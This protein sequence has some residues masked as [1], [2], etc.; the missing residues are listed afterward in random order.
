MRAIVVRPNTV[1]ARVPVAVISA[2]EE[3]LAGLAGSSG[4]ACRAARRRGMRAQLTRIAADLEYVEFKQLVTF[5]VLFLV[6]ASAI[7]IY[8]VLVTAASR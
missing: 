5:V 6:V 7:T 3:Y 2:W 8:N 1:V 4:R